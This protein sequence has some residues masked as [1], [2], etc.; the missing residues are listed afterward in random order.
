MERNTTILLQ[1]EGEVEKALECL[2]SVSGL[3]INVKKCDL[4]PLKDK[5]TDLTEIQCEILLKYVDAN[6]P[7]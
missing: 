7:I 1:N 2:L 6:L 5:P 4:F 3:R